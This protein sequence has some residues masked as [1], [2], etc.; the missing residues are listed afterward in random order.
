MKDKHRGRCAGLLKHAVFACCLE[1]TP[2]WFAHTKIAGLHEAETFVLERPAEI[3]Q[4]VDEGLD[5]H[6]SIGAPEGAPP[7]SRPS[8]GVHV[9]DKDI[10]ARPRHAR[11]FA[12]ERADIENMADGKRTHHHVR[13]LWPK[14]KRTS[15]SHHEAAAKRLLGSGMSDHLRAGIHSYH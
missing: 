8:R 7:S 12:C 9:G 11:Q 2:F 14:R 15:V 6:C 4:G 5:L 3:R 1:D 10:G 13:G